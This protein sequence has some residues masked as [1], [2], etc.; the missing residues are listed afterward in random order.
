VRYVLRK[1][2]GPAGFGFALYGYISAQGL[3]S[4]FASG[5]LDLVLADSETL[6]QDLPHARWAVTAD[7]Q[8]VVLRWSARLQRSLS[9]AARRDLSLAINRPALAGAA[10]RGAF[11]AARAFFE[12]LAPQAQGPSS[13]LGWDSRLA[14][15]DWL[16]RGAAG[17][18]ERLRLAVLPHAL[19]EAIARRLAGQWQATL[20]IAAVPER[21]DADRLLQAWNSGGYDA[22]VDVVDLDDGSLQDLWSAAL[23]GELPRQARSPGDVPSADDLSRWEARLARELPYVPLLTRLEV[24]AA[25]GDTGSDLAQ[26]ICPACALGSEPPREGN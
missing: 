22:M 19:L 5:N 14:R 1:Q 17:P 20:D 11:R 2:P 26:R 12:P 4:A 23:P 15:K 3:W 9:P 16:A 10:G 7:T 13:A 18:V 24:Y 21:V 25:R 8:Q 6:L